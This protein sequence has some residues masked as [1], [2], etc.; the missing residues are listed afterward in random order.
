[1]GGREG[2]SF[3]VA[4]SADSSVGIGW[5]EF[6]SIMTPVNAASVLCT[7]ACYGT[8]VNTIDRLSSQLLSAAANAFSAT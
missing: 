2:F 8:G 1:V 3:F 4:C 5:G 6:V 7:E